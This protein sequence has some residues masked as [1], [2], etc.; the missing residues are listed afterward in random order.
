MKR[1]LTLLFLLGTS[2]VPGVAQQARTTVEAIHFIKLANSFR[3]LDRSPQAIN[4][5]MRALPAVR[6][7]NLYWEAVTYEL[8]GLAHNEQE[9]PVEA[10]RYLQ[11]ART[12]YRKLKYEEIRRQ[13]LGR[14]RTDSYDLR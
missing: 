14:R 7:K 12:R 2:A 9:N 8:L 4:L 11:Q 5:L 6:S 13:R 10:V 3:A 1:F